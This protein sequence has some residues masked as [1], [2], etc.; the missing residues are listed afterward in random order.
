[1][2]RHTAIATSR[3]ARQAHLEG[4]DLHANV[5]VSANDR[6]G[7]ERLCRYVLRLPFAQERLRTDGRVALTLRPPRGSRPKKS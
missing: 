7:M 4:F 3:G 6:A 1:M 2:Q 5:W